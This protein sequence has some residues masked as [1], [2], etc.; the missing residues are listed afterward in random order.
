MTRSDMSAIEFLKLW[1]S[2]KTH[3]TDHNPSV[4]VS[5]KAD[6]WREV[7]DWVYQNWDI[8]GGLSFLPFDEH[9]YVQ[10]PYETVSED[11]YRLVKGMM[12]ND[13]D[14]KLLET[15]EKEDRTEGQQQLA[16]T[17]GVCEI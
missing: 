12:P 16:C 2:Y 7:G 3:W 1:A 15:I 9:T 10:A 5:V 8:V 11:I 14:W 4:T 13:I 6:E 17:A